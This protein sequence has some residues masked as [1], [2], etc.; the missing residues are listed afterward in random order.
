M[1]LLSH[2]KSEPLKI[3]VTG[4]RTLPD[5]H[6]ITASVRKTLREI[7]NA[8]RTVV[9]LSALA[10]GADRLVPRIALDDNQIEARLHAL[11]PF[12]QA[13]YENTFGS[14]NSMAEF[15]NMLDRAESVETLAPDIPPNNAEERNAAYEAC[16]F[17]M[18]DRCDLL[19]AVWDGE[20]ARGRGGTGDVVR[21]ARE[22]M[23]P[24]AWIS[25]LPPFSVSYERIG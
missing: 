2:K 21:Y 16:G 25:T 8:G 1:F 4:H 3:G 17:A 6:A 19:I 11:L 18:I 7:C 13:V 10:E 9:I 23:L 12:D 15:R 20:P 24:L 22:K 14:E 5:N